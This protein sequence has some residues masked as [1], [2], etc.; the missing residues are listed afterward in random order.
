[1]LLR[2]TILPFLVFFARFLF[3]ALLTHYDVNLYNVF[4]VSV[5]INAFS[6]FG[7][8]AGSCRGIIFACG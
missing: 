2:N 8:P 6:A 5:S 1:M 3:L 4:T 7:L